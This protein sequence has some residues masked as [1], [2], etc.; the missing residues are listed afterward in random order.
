MI[1]LEK[2]HTDDERYTFVESLLASAFPEAERRDTSAQRYMTDNNPIFYCFLIKTETEQLG[3]ITA[4]DFDRFCYIEHFAID[5]RFR[6][7]GYGRDAIRTLMRIVGR[8]FVLE[9]ELP[10]NEISR[11]RISFYQRQGFNLWDTC[12]YIQPP[13]REGGETLPMHIMASE[14]LDP[15]IYFDIVKRRLY[16]D[17]YQ[18]DEFATFS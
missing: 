18:T 17:V 2:I 9:V 5:E 11:H 8:P 7:S 14:D 13:Y 4:W 16:K 6:N 1:F 15:D 10:E 3:F 12:D